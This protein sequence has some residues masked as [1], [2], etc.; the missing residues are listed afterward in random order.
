[1]KF[2]DVE[3]DALHLG[4]TYKC[5]LSCLEC[6][7]TNTDRHHIPDIVNTTHL[8]WHKYKTLID[9][10]KP[11]YVTLCGNWGDPIYYPYLFDLI[12][13]IKQISNGKIILHTNGSYRD[14]DWWTELASVMTKRDEI[15]FSIDGTK[16]SFTKYRVNADIDSIYTAVKTIGKLDFKTR[17]RLIQK[18][19]LF[20]YV[21]WDI[22]KIIVEASEAK[23]DSILFHWP[24]VEVYP[25]LKPDFDIE[26]VK[27]YLKKHKQYRFSYKNGGTE[28]K[29][30]FK[31][32]QRS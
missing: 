4:L 2:F 17:P 28:I 13:Y 30:D 12:K 29:R 25:E 7:R 9:A 10:V 6:C 24:H 5:T 18:T 11:R 8:D 27:T 23:F 22:M 20:K 14:P 19:I 1:M 3:I 21:K 15:L 16:D 31:R 32:V 26:W